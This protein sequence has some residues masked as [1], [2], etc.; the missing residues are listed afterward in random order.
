[1]APNPIDINARR[2]LACSLRW[3]GT[4]PRRYSSE[5]ARRKWYAASRSRRFAAYMRNLGK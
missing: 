3:D 1:M 5:A 4:R 2:V